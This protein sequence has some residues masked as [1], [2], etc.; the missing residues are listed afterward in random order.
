VLLLRGHPL[1]ALELLEP[2]AGEAR[3]P[4]QRYL[5]GL[6]EGRAHE[7]LG[8]HAAATA[9][10]RRAVS[11]GGPAQTALLALA[12]A[13]PRVG[14]RTGAQN[15]LARLGDTGSAYD[16]WWSYGLGQPGRL[17]ALRQELRELVR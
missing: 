12:H 3:D 11:S 14:D 9:A 1:K 15:T 2:T 17:R 7:R 5:A 4:R 8:D 6:F 16:P 10:Y 13:L